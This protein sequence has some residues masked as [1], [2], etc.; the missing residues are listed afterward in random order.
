MNGCPPLPSAIETEPQLLETLYN[1]KTNRSLLLPS[2]RQ[3]ISH[4][5]RK[6][7]VW[8]FAFHFEP[9]LAYAFLE[10]ASM[11]ETTPELLTFTSYYIFLFKLTAGETDLCIGRS[12]DGVSQPAP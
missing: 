4:Q 6:S 11:M 5:D 1:Y 7:L 12:K 3:R 8:S 9:N 10:S 2:D